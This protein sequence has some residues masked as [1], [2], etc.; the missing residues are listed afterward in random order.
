MNMKA[1]WRTFSEEELKQIVSE[2]YSYRELAKRLGY[3][4]DGGGT[5]RSLHN[6]VEELNLDV[7]H[8]KG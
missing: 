4:Q 8:F 6:M 3:K 7:S 5:I 1:K 2:V